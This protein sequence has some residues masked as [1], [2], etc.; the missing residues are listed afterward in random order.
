MKTKN[1]NFKTGI[2]A[3]GALALTLAAVIPVANSYAWGPERQT[4]TNAS[5]ADHVQFNSIT[6]NAGIGDE[7]DFVRISEVTDGTNFVWKNEVA[8]TPGKTYAIMVYYHNN[9]ASNLNAQGTGMAINARLSSYFP[10]TV[11]NQGKGQVYARISADNANPKTVWDEAYFT[12][13]STADV[14]LRYVS[15]SAKLMNHGAANGTLLSD[16]DLFSDN[17]ILL[18]YNQ[19]IG[20]LPGCA[21]YSGQVIYYVRAEQVGAS[22]QK[23]ASLDGVNFFENVTAK[24]GDKITYKVEFKNTGTS[25][26]TNVTFHDLLPEGVTLVPGT[27]KLVNAANPNGVTMVD[28]IGQNGFKTGTYGPGATAT[29]TYQVTVNSDIVTNLSCGTHKYSNTI[30]A[31]HDAGEV[32]D[33]STFT[34]NKACDPDEPDPA[35][36]VDPVDPEEPEELPKT[37]PAEILLAVVAIVCIATGVAYWYHSQK[38]FEKVS[39]KIKPADKKSDKSDKKSD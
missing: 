20:N 31:D 9:A 25:D 35:D 37:G 30:F 33:S 15:A 19:L 5:P 38:E 36:P 29:L 18:G 14:V 12:S 11:N 24:P 22:V 6:D 4:Y 10:T 39:A 27:T 1:I 21:E 13:T 34:V 8:V 32:Y 16:V 23:T 3:A 7:R 26:L 2:K 28:L 17:G